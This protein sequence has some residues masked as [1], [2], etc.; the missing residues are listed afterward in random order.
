MVRNLNNLINCNKYVID[1]YIF[2]VLGDELHHKMNIS[3]S[4]PT[5]ALIVAGMRYAGLVGCCLVPIAR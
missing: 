2:D 3:R 5:L 4:P 1:F